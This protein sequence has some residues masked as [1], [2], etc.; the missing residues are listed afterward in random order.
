M[1]PSGHFKEVS[2][3][4]S[5]MQGRKQGEACPGILRPAACSEALKP[6]TPSR[7]VAWQGPT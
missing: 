2:Q 4:G 3:T 7:G 5:E 6:P 1:F